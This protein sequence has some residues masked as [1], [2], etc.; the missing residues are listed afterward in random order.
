[1]HTQYMRVHGQ[2]PGT[3]PCTRNNLS[4][5]S[6]THVVWDWNG[7]LL[8]DLAI[9]IESLN[10]GIGH[11]GVGPIGEEGY[12]DH[13][14]RPVRSFYDSLLGR[15]VTDMEWAHLDKTFHDEYFRR[16]GDAPLATDAIEALDR[17]ERMG[18]RQSLLSMTTHQQLVDIVTSHGI[19]D[20]FVRID[21]LTEA[22]GGLK[23]MHLR[24]HLE[25]MGVDPAGVVVVG[26]T[27]DDA[28]AARHVGARAVLY[29]G[30]SHHLP[31]L[32]A[33]DGPVAHTLLD[34]LDWVA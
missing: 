17:V 25:M 24:R 12:R 19:A 30:G 27:P 10:V 23:A 14:T 22:T 33:M 9:V 29:D 21:G 7:T 32:L 15:A 2:R 8:D 31:T 16:V 6:T 4:A 1:M 26:D 11:F 18:C 20:R 13:F 28:V 5:M 3:S 34:A